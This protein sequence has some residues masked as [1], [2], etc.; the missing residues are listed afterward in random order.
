MCSCRH[1]HH[2]S[3]S[4]YFV[5]TVET[6]LTF[7]SRGSI[8]RCGKGI[9]SPT[10]NFQ[11]RLSCGV[12]TPPCAMWVHVKD[13]VVHVRVRL[14]METLKTPSVHPRLGSATLSQLAFRGEVSY[15]VSWCFEPSQ[16][17]RITSGLNTNF[18]RSPS[19]SFHKSSYHKSCFL[20]LF[21]IPRALNTG[22]CIQQGD[23]SYSAGLHRNLCQ[24]KPTQEKIRRGF[25]KDAGEWSGR[26]EIGKEEIPSR[27]R[28]MYGSILNC[29]RL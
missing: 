9:F 23:L 24:P 11:C 1:F 7:S 5:Y 2:A 22:T 17:Q 12:R 14:I 28:S 6:D 21:Y 8:P 19:Y 4:K 18:T 3:L 20:S 27:K 13:H 26:V 29:S 25:G 10:V 15:L 16:P